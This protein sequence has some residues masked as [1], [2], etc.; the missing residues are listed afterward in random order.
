MSTTPQIDTVG[1]F[2]GLA[3]EMNNHPDQY[4]ILGDLELDIVVVM[5]RPEGDDFRVRLVFEGISCDGVSS[6]AEGEEEAADCWLE[7]DLSAWQ[8]MFDDIFENGK[9]TGRQ[10][11]NSLT[12]IGDDLQV[13][14]ADPLGIDKFF[15]FNQTMQ[16]FFDGAGIAA[17]AVATT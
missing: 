4:E 5:R 14:G 10:T 15:R 11:V 17:N 3:A 2:D 13:R 1:F 8:T 9:A 7:G 16:W 12:M 6:A